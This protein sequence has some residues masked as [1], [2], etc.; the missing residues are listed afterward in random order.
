MKTLVGREV[1]DGRAGCW[2][3][4]PVSKIC[5]VEEFDGTRMDVDSFP[6][7]NQADAGTLYVRVNSGLADVFRYTAKGQRDTSDLT[8]K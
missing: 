2:W 8:D 4:D 6:C 3:K 5:F 1:V 7:L